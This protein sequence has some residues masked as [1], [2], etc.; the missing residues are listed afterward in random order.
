MKVLFLDHQG[1]M[2]TKKHPCPGKLDPFNTEA[3]SILNSILEL[4]NTIEIVI[5]SDWKYWVPL[6]EMC[7]FYQAQGILKTPIAY[8]PKT[9]DY[10]WNQYPQQRSKEINTWLTDNMDVNNI[11]KWVAIDDIDMRPYLD[12]FVWV[13]KPAEGIL[14]DGI[15]DSLLQYLQD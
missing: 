14:Q 12:N 10:I 11:T 4:D 9:A 8:T 5:S 2:Y 3:V 15:K 1:V 6:K 13:S 7:E